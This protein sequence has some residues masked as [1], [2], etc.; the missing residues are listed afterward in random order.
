METVNI[1]VKIPKDMIA[2]FQRFLDQYID[3]TGFKILPNTEKMYNEDQVFREKVK[4]K[5]K[6]ACSI[7][8][9][10]NVFSSILDIY[11]IISRNDALP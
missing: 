10:Y 9:I 6:L 4:N 7:M 3:V 11:L 5:K 8:I 2:E 1:T